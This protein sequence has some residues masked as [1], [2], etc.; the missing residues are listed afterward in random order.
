MENSWDLRT[1]VAST[2]PDK[3]VPLVI[4]RKGEVKR[5]EVTLVERTLEQQEQEADEGISLDKTPDRDRKRKS[6]SKYARSPLGII[7]DLGS[8]MKLVC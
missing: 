1:A 2:P 3:L 7:S 6:V 8:M 5:I 4:V